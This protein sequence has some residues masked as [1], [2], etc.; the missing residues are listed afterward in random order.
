MRAVS[1]AITAEILIYAG[2]GVI[3]CM[4]G[5]S[6]GKLVFDKLN[7]EK[8]KLIIYIGMIISGILMII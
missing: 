2:I 7:A 5:D 8:L 1:G 6:L 3:G 4:V